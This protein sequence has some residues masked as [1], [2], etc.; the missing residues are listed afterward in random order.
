MRDLKNI[1]EL[2]ERHLVGQKFNFEP[3]ELS[4]PCNYMVGLGG[5]RIRP[6]LVLMSYELFDNRLSRA[7]PAAL[8]VELF[9]NFTLIHD[10]IMDQAPLRRGKPTVHALFDTNTAI[11][12]GDALLILAYSNL[13]QKC[14]GK[15]A[16]KLTAILNKVGME[17]CQGQQMDMNFEKATTVSLENYIQMIELKTAVLLGGALKMG[18]IQAKAPE[19]DAEALDAF[20]KLAGIAFQIQDDLL[21]TYGDPDLFG[22]Q[23]GGD[24]LQNKKTFLVLKTLERASASDQTALR[25]LME[26]NALAPDEKILAVKTLFDRYEIFEETQKAKLDFQFRAFEQLEKVQ[27]STEKKAVLAK[28]FEELLERQN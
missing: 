20:G 1:V 5:K 25:Q 28:T 22:K 26:N 19:K 3:T 13:I 8:A 16:K 21:D 11:L 2:F 9:H 14:D 23:T 7:L 27:V 6:A 4:N 15:T 17:V 18:A 10:D 24:I 12:S